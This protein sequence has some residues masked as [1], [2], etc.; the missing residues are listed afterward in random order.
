MRLRGPS[1]LF[2]DADLGSRHDARR[3]IVNSPH[4]DPPPLLLKNGFIPLPSLD[5]PD[6]TQ[7]LDLLLDIIVQPDE[8]LIHTL[9]HRDGRHDLGRAR[10]P[11]DRVELHRWTGRGVFDGP[12]AECPGIV[13]CAYQARTSTIVSRIG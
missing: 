4:G 11:Y 1:S 12:G 9:H 2:L 6:P 7:L 5:D 10:Q 13:E 8:T 3:G